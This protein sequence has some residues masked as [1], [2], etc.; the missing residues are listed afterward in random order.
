MPHH[1]PR[2]IHC[3]ISP[4]FEHG[5]AVLKSDFPIHSCHP[6]LPPSTSA[7]TL[8][9]T[10]CKLTLELCLQSLLVIVCTGD[11]AQSPAHARLYPV[12]ALRPSPPLLSLMRRDPGLSFVPKLQGLAFCTLPP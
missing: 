7:E 1:L 4:A 12:T 11:G 5:S 3:S 6:S 8:T 9:S 10:T 2:E